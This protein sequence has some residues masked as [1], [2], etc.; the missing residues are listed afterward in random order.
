LTASI[1]SGDSDGDSKDEIFICVFPDF[2]IAERMVRRLSDN[3]PHRLPIQTTS[4]LVTDA[5]HGWARRVW[6]GDGERTLA[7]K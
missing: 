5:K 7:W 2:Y 1:S 4:T 6:I 3:F